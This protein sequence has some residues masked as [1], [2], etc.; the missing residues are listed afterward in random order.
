MTDQI[1]QPPTLYPDGIFTAITTGILDATETFIVF[2]NITTNSLTVGSSSDNYWFEGPKLVGNSSG[3]FFG[4]GVCIF[5]NFAIVGSSGN[6]SSNYANIYENIGGL[7]TLVETLNP[8]SFVYFGTSV[9]IVSYSTIQT[10]LISAGSYNTIGGVYVY[11]NTGSGW[12]QV[13]VLTPSDNIGSSN[14][15]SSISESPSLVFI[16]IQT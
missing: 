11:Q 1:P 14:F 7:W 8:G 10:A 4:E 3:S 12:S 13:T 5:E 2:D 6:E 15:G 9:A 16:S